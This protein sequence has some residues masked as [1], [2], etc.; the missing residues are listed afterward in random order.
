MTK[1]LVVF[2]GGLDSTVALYW[3][4]A[5][6]GVV[7]TVTFDYGAKHNARE[8]AYAR[9]TC[10]KLGVE[11]TVL[12][13]GFMDRYFKSNL[14]RSGGAVPEGHYTAENMKATVVPFRNGIMLAVAAGLAESCDCGVLILGNH[15]GDHAIYPDC[16]PEFI[17]GMR[18]AVRAGTEKQID[19][20]SP[21]C[22]SD[23]AAIVRLGKELG[24]DFALTYSCYKGGIKHCGKCGTCVERREAFRL[25]GV[26]DPSAYEEIAKE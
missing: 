3:A 7:A 8:G 1:A 17:A 12:D 6:Y 25:A 26:E 22:D 19:V 10:E 23:K 18:A 9:R 4:R 5:H 21:F 15:S 11:N 13:L 16:R 2:S 20:V 24:V 14:L